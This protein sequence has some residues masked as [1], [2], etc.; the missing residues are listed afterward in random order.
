MCIHLHLAQLFQFGENGIEMAIIIDGERYG[1]FR[2]GNHV[3][4]RAV[5]FKDAENCS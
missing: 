4:R 2:S 5:L 1:H 3:D